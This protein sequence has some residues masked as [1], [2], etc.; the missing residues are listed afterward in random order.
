MT[1][2]I[3]V[4][5]IILSLL[6]VILAQSSDA[7]ALSA[8]D[9][10][11]SVIKPNGNGTTWAVLIA[12][13]NGYYNY[14][15][16]ADVCHAYQILKKGGLKDE[17]IIVFMYDDIA[18]DPNNPRPGV[19]IN[20]PEGPD[21]Y[22]GVPKD[23]TGEAVKASNFYA[24]LL[25]DTKATTGG[26]G[27]VVASKP[28]DKIFLYY[29]DHGGPGILGLPNTPYIFANDFIE[30]LKR[31]HASGTYDE[32]VIYL[33]A[34]ESGSIFEGL[35]PNDLNIYVT[36]A[37]NAT[38]NS[39]ATYCPDTTSPMPQ[40]FDTC[41]GDLY[42]VSWMEDSDSQDLRVETL[43]QQYLKVK[44]RT[45]N[46]NSDMGSNVMQYGT[47]RISNETVSV[48][49]G[50]TAKELSSNPFKKFNS[51]GVINQRDADLYS[52]WHMYKK[53]TLEIQKKN[54]LLRKIKEITAHRARLDKSVNKIK[55]YLLGNGHGP[56]RDEGSALV[57]DWGCL[58]FMVRTFEKYCGT[59]TQ[60]GMKHTRTFANI[61]N[62]GV[63][64]KAMD[65]A[66]KKS[67]STFKLGQW[68]PVVAGYSA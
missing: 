4:F 50:S 24:V 7:N 27:K 68:D 61:C 62:N 38:E 65:E 31:K 34:C 45:L 63:A 56:V 41:L 8:L 42:S 12:G 53:P 13:S 11:R 59:L 36:T 57:D 51:M 22:A 9:T 33:E 18:N 16:Q 5:Q 26:S 64:K 10:F 54:E 46:N 29:S 19:I 55:R 48:Y 14:R 58:K 66:A 17:N 21:V 49:Q 60:Y 25:G 30:I 28:G 39:W 37:S 43:E 44:E 15:H 23:Y 32:M 35:L 20:S 1:N 67:C 40:G 52:M 47:L 2:Q 6:I 3:M